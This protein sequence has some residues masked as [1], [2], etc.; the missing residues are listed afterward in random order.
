MAGLV[1]TALLAVALSMA[2][3]MALGS[4]AAPRPAWAEDGLS[5]LQR[6]EAGREY[7]HAAR[8]K[9]AQHELRAALERTD[10][11][12]RQRG[13]AWF[14]LG[15]VYAAQGYDTFA[16]EAFAAARAADPSLSPDPAEHSPRLRELWDLTEPG[17]Q[18]PVPAPAAPAPGEGAPVDPVAP[19]PETAPP[20][21]FRESPLEEGPPSFRETPLGQ[22]SPRLSDLQ[23]CREVRFGRPVGVATA[24]AP[25]TR[26]IHLWFAM[27]N[28]PAGARVKAVWSYLAPEPMEILASEVEVT[29]TGGWGQFSCQMGTG[30]DW[31]EGGYAVELFLDDLPAG[32]A[33]FS[34]SRVPPAGRGGS[35]DAL[36]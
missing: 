31:P 22:T 16:V 34:I 9:D 24:F 23:L 5:G 6:L 13:Q 25:Q 29:R 35:G 27:K 15:Q 19:A 32:R 36:H 10:L 12:P 33:A 21:G 30:R 1:W 18:A 8:F 7:F 26:T 11:S 28:V 20:D 17:G 3:G 14:L 4:A 2:W